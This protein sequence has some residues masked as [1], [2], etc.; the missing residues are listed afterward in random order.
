MSYY[1]TQDPADEDVLQGQLALRSY[2]IEKGAL[3]HCAMYP[4]TAERKNPYFNLQLADRLETQFAAEC[5]ELSVRDED[6]SPAEEFQRIDWRWVQGLVPMDTHLL[7]ST[8][9]TLNDYFGGNYA[10][11]GYNY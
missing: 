2:V 6:T 3:A 1:A 8:D 4:G 7:R 9:A 11:G 5:Q 10:S